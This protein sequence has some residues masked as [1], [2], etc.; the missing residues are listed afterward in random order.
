M[1]PPAAAT[2]PTLPPPTMADVMRVPIKGTNRVIELDATR[3]AAGG[4]AA[5]A[6]SQLVQSICGFDPSTSQTKNTID[7]L[8]GAKA[9]LE[10][11]PYTLFLPS[12]HPAPT[13]LITQHPPSSLH[14]LDRK[15]VV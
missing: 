5:L 10:Q 12:P 8:L 4:V 6:L 2:A 11:V 15:S 14:L 13:P 1:T 7:S 3:N 9:H